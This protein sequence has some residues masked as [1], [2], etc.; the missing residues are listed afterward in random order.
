MSTYNGRKG[1]VTVG[2]SDDKILELQEWGID[3]D[4]NEIDVS[5][6]GSEWG[7]SDVGIKRWKAKASGFGDPKDTTGQKV[8]MDAWKNETLIQDLKFWFSDTEYYAPDTVTD[9]NAGIRVT[10][11]SISQNFDNVLK[12]DFELSADGP[13][14]Q[15]TYT[16]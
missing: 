15:E 14:I 8:L 13:V 3:F 16:P 4:S 1:K 6:F 9:A 10:K 2:A 11:Y 12:V 5:A 7:K